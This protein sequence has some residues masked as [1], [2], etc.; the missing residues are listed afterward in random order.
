MSDP[1]LALQKAIVATLKAANTGAG[2]NVFDSVP[3]SNPFPRITVGDGQSLADFQDCRRGSEV[4]LDVHV[5]SRAVG[6][7]EAKT[8]ASETRDAL[9]DAALVL[10]GHILDLLDFD[11]ARFLRDP[12]GITSHV[13][14]SFRALTQPFIAPPPAPEGV[15]NAA[16]IGT[17]AAFS[18]V[19]TGMS[20][21][22]I[23]TG[24]ALAISQATIARNGAAAGA[25]LASAVGAGL[26]ATGA[27]SAVGVGTA[28]A[29][30]TG[31]AASGAGS[32]AAVGAALAVGTIVRPGGGSASGTGA[33][34][35]I[36]SSGASNAGALLFNLAAQSGLIALL[37][38]V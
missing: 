22:A 17:A 35:A 28:A 12:D 4:F 2:N 9:D 23:G 19:I 18:P 37:E 32:A 34:A 26:A 5:W 7:P 1:S 13:A 29:V 6:Y 3:T 16:G 20:G 38:D 30:G 10:D 25:G 33:A 31:L 21:A 24:T 15:G 36:G 27:G 14:M 8:I 11:E